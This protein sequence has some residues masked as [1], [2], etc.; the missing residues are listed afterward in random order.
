MGIAGREIVPVYSQG[1]LAHGGILTYN[2][3]SLV[4]TDAAAVDL[5]RTLGEY[6]AVHD[7][8]VVGE[9]PETCPQAFTFIEEMRNIKSRLRLWV[10]GSPSLLAFG[11]HWRRN[12][13][14]PAIRSWS[15]STGNGS[16]KEKASRSG[17]EYNIA[18][19]PPR[20]V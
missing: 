6:V 1:A 8:V 7:S 17:L 2:D 19:I 16:S 15:G 11:K 12:T 10:E 4:M 3:P 13:L 18:A 20:C 9:T 5:S 14:R